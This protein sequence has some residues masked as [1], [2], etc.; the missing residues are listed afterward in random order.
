M[1]W[2]EDAKLTLYSILWFAKREIRA[3]AV[4]V[5]IK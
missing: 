1:L 4:H 5:L 2:A 3:L